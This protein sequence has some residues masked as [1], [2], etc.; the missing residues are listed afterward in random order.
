M[1]KLFMFRNMKVIQ[2]KFILLSVLCLL[3]FGCTGKGNKKEYIG[4]KTNDNGDSVLGSFSDSMEVYRKIE[5]KENCFIVISKKYLCLQVYEVVKKDT[6]LTAFFP[7]C[8]SRN[9]GKK[10]VSGD[11]RTPESSMEEPFL[12]E[13]IQDAST[14]THDFGDGRG[15]ILAYGNWFLRLS[16]G[17][18]G[19]GIHGST[20]NEKSVPGRDSEG[21]IRLRDKDIIFLKENYAFI[22]MKVVIQ[23]EEQEPYPFERHGN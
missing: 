1:V 18:K 2:F 9:K 16:T 14:W 3:I 19:I 10:Q 21:C 4:E 11:M 17:F 15:A 20:G 22:G 6:L 12:I 23:R 13:N 8:L 5:K 7:A